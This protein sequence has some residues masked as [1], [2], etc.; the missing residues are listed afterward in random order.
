MERLLGALKA[1]GEPTRLRILAILEQHE[2][3]VSELVTV[4]GQSQPR[5]SRHLK[6]LVE[7][8][9]L[10]R[11]T[12]GTSAFY[13]L[14]RS[15]T[16]AQLTA[17]VLDLVDRDDLDI[18]R[19]DE[20][21]AQVHTKRAAVAA[22]YFE[23]A[24][25]D[26][27]HMRN[28]HVPDAEIEAA[29]LDVLGQHRVGNRPITDLLDLGTGTGRILEICGGSINN[30]LGIDLS[31]EML[32]VARDRLVRNQLSH[33]SVRLGDLTNLDVATASVDA[34][35]LHHV[36]HFLDNPSQAITEAARTLRTDGLLVIVDFAPHNL[37]SLRTDHA[38][39]RLGFAPADVETWCNAAGLT[40]VQA[41]HFAPPSSE[42]S[43]LLTVTLWTARQH[44]NAAS[45]YTLEVA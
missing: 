20:R 26:W 24:A 23:K 25:R 15:G 45:T 9:V 41:Q 14:N 3:T 44:S 16:S 19:D 10:Q 37:E 35:V 8:D 18:I 1:V 39:R 38:H 21:L 22:T 42:H 4:L 5:V 40:D 36:L 6:I 12:E 11:H 33:C 29:L 31:R 7:A 2:L 34:A 43:D 30:G 32:A 27:D 17:A 13:R 28:R